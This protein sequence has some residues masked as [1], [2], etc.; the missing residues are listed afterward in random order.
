MVKI[1]K[2][3]LFGALQLIIAVN[4]C[5]N[6]KWNDLTS[7]NQL[8]ELIERSFE[9]PQLV[10]KHSTSCPISAVMKSRF[11]GDWKKQSILAED[12]THLLDLLAYRAISNEIAQRFD[13][14]HES[15]QILIIDKGQ[16]IYH[17]SH[18]AISMN[19]LSEYLTK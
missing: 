19:I 4:F 7:L 16:S 14:R 5:L 9:K 1:P 17:A 18:A 6:M 13:V 15:P 3:Y 2:S 8:D 11:E 10:F 12:Q